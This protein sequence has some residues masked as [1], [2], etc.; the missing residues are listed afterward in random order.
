MDLAC[1]ERNTHHNSPRADNATKVTGGNRPL[2]T[3]TA[4]SCRSL[5]RC[6]RMLREIDTELADETVSGGEKWRLRQRA[7]LIRGF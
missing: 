7:E 5:S 1:A 6:P 3:Q 4:L 2:P